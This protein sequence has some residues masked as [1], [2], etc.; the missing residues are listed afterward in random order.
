[1]AL[2][3]HNDTPAENQVTRRNLLVAA[4]AVG[5]SAVIG[6]QAAEAAIPVTVAERVVELA[7]EIERLL[8]GS[9]PEGVFLKDFR[10][11]VQDSDFITWAMWENPANEWDCRPAHFRPRYHPDWRIQEPPRVAGVTVSAIRG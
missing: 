5:L 6:A 2:A 10:W 8:I 9:A 1:M 11:N 3:R 4:P 7:R